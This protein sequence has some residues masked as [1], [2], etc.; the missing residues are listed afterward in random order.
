MPS[1]IALKHTCC[2]VQ[3]KQVENDKLELQGKLLD[4]HAKNTNM[5][6]RL[7]ALETTVKA[8]STQGNALPVL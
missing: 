6:K 1:Y 3:V 7:Q 4:V 2:I 5:T 8:S